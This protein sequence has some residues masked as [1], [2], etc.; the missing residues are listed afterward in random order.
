MEEV[1]LAFSILILDVPLLFND[2]FLL[3]WLILIPWWVLQ[4]T[5][6]DLYFWPH[7]HLITHSQR[8]ISIRTQKHARR[9]FRMVCKCSVANGKTM[10][11]NYQILLHDSPIG[12]F[13]RPHMVFLNFTPTKARSFTYCLIS[14]LK[15]I[16]CGKCWFL[17]PK[18]AIHCCNSFLVVERT[19]WSNLLFTL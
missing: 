19:R 18:S 9:N 2:D 1:P 15:S 5:S 4:N 11:Q 8:S 12:S 17:N 16:M 13:Q 10:F 7:D 6:L 14:E 3:G